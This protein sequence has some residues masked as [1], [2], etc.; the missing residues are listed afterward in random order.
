MTIATAPSV[1]DREATV[2]DSGRLAGLSV[3]DQDETGLVP[4]HA[5]AVLDVQELCGL[6]LLK[7]NYHVGYR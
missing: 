6:R 7:V 3:A 1:S 4:S 2:D 5:Y